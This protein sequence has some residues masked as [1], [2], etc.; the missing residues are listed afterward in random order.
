MLDSFDMRVQVTELETQ[1]VSVERLD[2]YCSL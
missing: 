2:A 1:V